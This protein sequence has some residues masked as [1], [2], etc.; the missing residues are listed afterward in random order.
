MKHFDYIIVGTGQ[1]TGTLLGKLIPTGKS[2]AVIEGNKVGGSCVNYGCTPTKTLVASA[3][4]MYQAQRGGEFGFSINGFNLDFA[5]IYERMN[6][7][8]NSG[9]DGLEKWMNST[10]NV[11]LFKEWAQFVGPKE[12]KVG[13]DTI[14]GETIF[15]NTGTH[16]F[17]PPIK[18]ADT[19]QLLDSAGLLALKTLPEKLVI[20]GGGYIGLEF[21]QIFNRFGSEVTILEAMPNFMSREDRDVADAVKN[22][23]ES[24]GITIKTDVK[25]KEVKATGKEKKV[26]YEQ[27]GQTHQIAANAITVA[28]GRRPN[29]VKLGLENAAIK[30]N[31]RGFIETNDVAETSIP[32]IFA[33]GDVN[34]KGAFTHT[35]VHDTQVVLA[36]LLGGKRK[37]SDRNT[38]Y[39]LFIDP[40][41]GRVGMTEQQARES[42]KKVLMATKDMKRISR[43]KEMSETKGFIKILVDAESRTLIGASIFGLNGDEAINFLAL[44]LQHKLTVE[45]IQET[46]LVH[47]TVSELL[48]FILDGL[49]EV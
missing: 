49:K 21:A 6:D 25:V 16:A 7:I 46:V 45:Q 41:L 34:G 40:P 5:R 3:K 1:A 15:I 9:S 31:D 28:T 35:S 33:L 19:V 2:I 11:D 47:P 13:N 29:T 42:G 39:S 24:E 32:G 17:I 43:A 14:S 27:A 8:R 12:I 48:P 4:A 18:G 20:I 36:H 10:D 23:L 38:I 26:I 22:V 37:I 30:V 44:A